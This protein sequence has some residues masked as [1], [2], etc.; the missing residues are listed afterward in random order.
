MKNNLLFV[1]SLLHS[2]VRQIDCL[3]AESSL[4]ISRVFHTSPDLLVDF[5]DQLFSQAILNL[6]EI[7]SLTKDIPAI[8]TIN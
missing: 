7:F 2:L 6:S 8:F 4:F 1:S 5:Q 3:P